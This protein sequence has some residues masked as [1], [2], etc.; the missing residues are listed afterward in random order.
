[1]EALGHRDMEFAEQHFPAFVG[2]H[3]SWLGLCAFLRGDWEKASAWLERG[4][5]NPPAIIPGFSWGSWFQYLA[6]T[7]RRDEALAFFE[8]KRTELPTPGQPNRWTAWTLLMAF[9]EGLFVLGERNEPADWYPLMLEARATGAI[10]TDNFEGRLLERVAGIA[11][12]AAGNWDTAE[13]HFLL[14]LGQADELP[15][16]LERL[17]TRRFYAQ[18][19]TERAGPGDRERAQLLLQEAIDGFSRLHM[20]RHADLA[21]AALV[22][23]TPELDGAER[24]PGWRGTSTA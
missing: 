9:T 1:M 16:Q 7:G 8:E 20:P 5:T 21:R 4:S 6:F 17:E 15:H 18:M 3:Y 11:A 22:A 2:H 12:S 19:L 13:A 10:A 14:A 23:V 24:Q